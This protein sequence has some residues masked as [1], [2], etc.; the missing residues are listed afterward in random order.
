MLCQNSRRIIKTL[1]QNG[2]AVGGNRQASRWAEM[3]Y[4]NPLRG[5]LAGHA[6]ES[7]ALSGKVACLIGAAIGDQKDL[8]VA[9]KASNHSS[10]R[11]GWIVFFEKRKAFAKGKAVVQI[12]Y[13]VAVA[14]EHRERH[15][16]AWVGRWPL[17][18][19]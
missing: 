4:R 7:Y 2:L 11:L 18:D 8:V 12:G 5:L 13:L 10:Q 16:A 3:L 17:R 14:V 19:R 15:Y 6:H 9:D 1:H